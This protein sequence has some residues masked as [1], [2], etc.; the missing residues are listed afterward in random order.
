MN[1]M[2]DWLMVII[3]AIYVIATIFICVFNGWSAKAAKQQT[4]IAKKQIEKMIEQ[5]NESNRPIITIRFDI[6]RA[7]LLC[8]VVENKGSMEAINVQIKI[9]SEFIDNIEAQNEFVRLRE[10]TESHLFLSSHQKIFIL[11]GGQAHFNQ[12]ANVIAKFNIT[13]NDKYSEYT[14]IDLSQYRFMLS[15]NSELDEIARHLNDIRHQENEFHKEYLKRLS[16]DS[17]VSVLVH[18]SDN[19]KKFEIYKAVCLNPRYNA[20]QIAMLVNLPKEDV[21]NILTELA[22]VDRF[23]QPITNEGINFTTEW[24]RK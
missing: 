11:L 1:N 21:L 8:F 24:H 9:N 19:S 23:I 16:K 18:T 12:I 15:Y 3:T 7:G 2:T 10:L 14:E 5:Y 20:E 6:I 13:Y 17:P 22:L 4:E